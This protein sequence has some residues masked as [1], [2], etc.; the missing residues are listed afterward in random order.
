MCAT[1]MDC[2]VHTSILSKMHK[3]AQKAK[4]MYIDVGLH[5]H[6]TTKV[7]GS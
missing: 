4:T 6:P 5:N 7:D 2:R 3:L 1:L